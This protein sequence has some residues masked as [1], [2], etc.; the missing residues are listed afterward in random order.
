MIGM[1]YYDIENSVNS[2][3][4]YKY[5]SVIFLKIYNLYF[6]SICINLI[7]YDYNIR[8]IEIIQIFNY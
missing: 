3:N 6:N 4:I 2:I 5:N 8:I 7:I 1:Y